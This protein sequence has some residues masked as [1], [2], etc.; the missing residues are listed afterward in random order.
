[1]ELIDRII[2]Y[3]AKLYADAQ[4]AQ[5]DLMVA[6]GDYFYN[7]DWQAQMDWHRQVVKSLSAVCSADRLDISE[8]D[9]V[10]SI[11]AQ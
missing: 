3:F 4:I 6:S 2:A 7:N 10:L 11:A 8:L 9:R 5:H 1:M